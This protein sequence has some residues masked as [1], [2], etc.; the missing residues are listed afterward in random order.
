[1]IE[2][3]INEINTAED[4]AAKL[5]SDATADAKQMCFNAEAEGVKMREK[6]ITDAKVERAEVIASAEK[7]AE[8]RYTEIVTAGKSEA[9]KVKAA[10]DGTAVATKLLKE[11][12]DK[13]VR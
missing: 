8:A 5:V 13:W 6:A 12:E 9:A 10:A 1:M 3:L 2:D 11:F 7:D 4:G